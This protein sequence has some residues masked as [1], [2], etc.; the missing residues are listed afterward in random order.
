MRKIIFTILFMAGSLTAQINYPYVVPGTPGD[1]GKYSSN[2][3]QI[4][5]S[6]GACGGSG[7][8]VYPGIGIPYTS[9]GSSW[10][11]SL[12]KFGAAAG[13]ATSTDPG[14]TAEVP[15]VADGTHG[16]K[17]SA[18][19]ALGTGAFAAVPTLSS[20]GAQAALTNPV[21]APSTLVPTTKPLLYGATAT[22]VAADTGCTTDGAGNVTCA[23]ITATGSPALTG[24]EGAAPSA[25]AATKDTLGLETTNGFVSVNSSGTKKYMVQVQAGTS[26]QFV[27]AIAATGVVTTAAIAAADVPAALSSTTSVNGTTIPSGGV[28]ITQTIASGTIALATSSIGT[29]SCQTVSQGSVNSAAATGT[30]TTDAIS[31]TPNGSIKAITG[32]V[33]ATTGGL[34]IAAYPTAGYVNFDVCNWTSGA[35]VPGAL[36]LN[37]R[38]VR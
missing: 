12:T 11:T 14:A 22:T 19:G 27:T 7:S 36:T 24:T 30:A 34:T 25:P 20:L 32:Y 2:G 10:G 1:C 5:D 38:V 6:G 23:S 33:P 4:I 8:M 35:I 31:F 29:G 16:Q 3:Y 28:T 21:T 18:S 9:N 13:L 26:H 37:W 17:P 15:M